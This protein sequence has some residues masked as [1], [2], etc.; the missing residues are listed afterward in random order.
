MQT[1]KCVNESECEARDYFLTLAKGDYIIRTLA[2]GRPLP[3]LRKGKLLQLTL[4]H[5]NVI[6]IDS[7]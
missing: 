2:L 1:T 4:L 6:K 5:E 7:M 3:I